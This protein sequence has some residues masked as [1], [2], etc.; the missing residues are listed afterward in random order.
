MKLRIQDNSA[1]TIEEYRLMVGSINRAVTVML[2]REAFLLSNAMKKGLIEQ[3]PGGRKIRPL[4]RSTILLRGLRTGGKPGTKALIDSGSMVNSV[5]ARKQSQFHFT[6][7]VHRNARAKDGK[8]LADIAAIHEYG[9]KTYTI[10]VTEKMRRFSFVLM[11][12]GILRAPWRVG[13]KLKRRTP[14]RPW[15]NPAHKEWE[16]D[17]DERFTAGLA[18]ILGVQR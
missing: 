11:A 12:A 18:A 9:T 5:I 14:E 1:P 13:Q 3:R 7:G 8:S 10:T 15:L 17:A 4:A 2:S 16:K 6:A